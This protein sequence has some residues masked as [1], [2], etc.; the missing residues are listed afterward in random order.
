MVSRKRFVGV[1]SEE[2]IEVVDKKVVDELS[3]KF[4][5]WMDLR[6]AALVVA[7]VDEVFVDLLFGFM[8]TVGEKEGVGAGEVEDR[9]TEGGF[10]EVDEACELNVTDRPIRRFGTTFV[11]SPLL[12]L[13][14]TSF[15]AKYSPSCV[16]R[17]GEL[18]VARRR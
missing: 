18:C 5:I 10:L 2:F 14:V 17:R 6:A 9:W 1:M 11:P 15:V 8:S 12:K 13:V 4:W 3:K 7:G 16:I